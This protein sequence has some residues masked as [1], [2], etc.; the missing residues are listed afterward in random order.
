MKTCHFNKL[1]KAYLSYPDVLK[2]SLKRKEQHSKIQKVKYVVDHFYID[3]KNL[4]AYKKICGFENN[5]II[6]AIY[7]SVLSQNLQLHMM[8][9]EALPIPILGL[10]HI[11]NEIKQYCTLFANRQYK[12]SCT[13]SEVYGH[14]RGTVLEFSTVVECE[15][16]EVVTCSSRYLS[17]K[18]IAIEK[19]PQL[20]KSITLDECEL[21]P[22]KEWYVKH[23][24]GIKYAFSSGDFNPIHLHRWGAKA[25]GFSSTIAH[26]MWSKAKVLA[27]LDLP[28][29]YEVFV[30]FKKPLYLS[31]FVE[32]KNAQISNGVHFAL[33][34]ISDQK[35]HLIGELK[36]S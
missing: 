31:S 17:R 16:K 1:P 23:N 34:S 10:I 21:R 36:V 5:S 27:N 3:A 19:L 18:F 4:V 6:P 15:G 25:F 11:E 26:G 35:T 24:T 14:A 32:L 9:N 2:A 28:E 29:A 33:Q 12:L 8:I 30:Q 13:L 22:V 7:F 20:N